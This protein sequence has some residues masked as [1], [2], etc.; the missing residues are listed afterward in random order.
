MIGY[1]ILGKRVGRSEYGSVRIATGS[2][3]LSIEKLVV[4]HVKECQG[5]VLEGV[6]ASTV[7]YC[8]S[9]LSI[10]VDISEASVALYRRYLT[11][12]VKFAYRDT[13]ANILGWCSLGFGIT[14]LVAQWVRR[15][16]E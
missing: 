11:D 2:L 15:I 14:V 6:E 12:Q 5:N 3:I 7:R 1:G 4:V 10:K 16:R 9:R 13:V 8:C